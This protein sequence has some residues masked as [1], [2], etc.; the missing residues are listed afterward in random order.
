M[1]AQRMPTSAISTTACRCPASTGRSRSTRRRPP[2]T[3]PAPTSVGTARAARHQRREGH[4]IPPG[5]Q[6]QGGRHPG[7]LPGG[8]AQPRPD[9]R[10]ARAD[11]VRLGADRQFRRARAGAARR[12][13]QPRRRQPRHDGVGQRRRRRADRQGAAGDRRRSSPT[14]DLG[15]GVTWQAQ[16][17][18][19]GARQGRRL[20]DEGVRHRDLPDLR[21]PA[22]AVQ[23]AHLGRRWCCPRSCCR[24]SACCSA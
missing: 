10:T 22:G 3:A 5:R 13:H 11:A 15:P 21:D 18:G 2:N 17:R 12:L 19:R 4:R 7:A 9:R 8:P 6:R 20:P 1:L 23:P 14:A 24:P 16:G